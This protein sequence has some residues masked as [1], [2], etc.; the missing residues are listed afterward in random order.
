MFDCERCG[1]SSKGEGTHT[2]W[3][4]RICAAC[5][6]LSSITDDNY[7]YDRIV[8]YIARAINATIDNYHRT[9]HE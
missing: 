6:E 9:V 3:G 2:A 5:S 8:I 1:S 7:D 4:E